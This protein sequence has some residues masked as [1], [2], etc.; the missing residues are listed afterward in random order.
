MNQITVTIPARFYWDHVERDCSRGTVVKSTKS[1]VT[2]TFTDE[3]FDDLLSDAEYYSDASQFSEPWLRGL[4]SSARAT[5]K[6][7]R[8]AR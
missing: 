2:V 4:S 1:K 5:L 6:V 3:E 8:A 7:L